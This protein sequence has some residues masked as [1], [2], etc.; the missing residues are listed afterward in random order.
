MRRAIRSSYLLLALAVLAALV[1]WSC[2]STPGVGMGMDTPA[3][4]SGGNGPPVF[5]GGPSY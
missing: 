3:R 5:V 1:S 4:W 2:V